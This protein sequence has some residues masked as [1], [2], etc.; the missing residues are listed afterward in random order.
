M[1]KGQGNIAYLGIFFNLL[2]GELAFEVYY[3]GLFSGIVPQIR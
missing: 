2:N 3:K 1:W